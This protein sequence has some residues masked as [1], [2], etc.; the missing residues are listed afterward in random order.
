MLTFPFVKY[1]AC[2]LFDVY[3][4]FLQSWLLTVQYYLGY[5]FIIFCYIHLLS[6]IT[7]RLHMWCLLLCCSIMDFV[8]CHGFPL[9]TL[10]VGCVVPLRNQCFSTL[11]DVLTLGSSRSSP[12]SHHFGWLVYSGYYPY[13]GIAMTLTTLINEGSRG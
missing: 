2:I 13:R 11:V 5:S 12:P 9:G 7:C 4:Y 10:F 8:F 6:Y 1:D 3:V